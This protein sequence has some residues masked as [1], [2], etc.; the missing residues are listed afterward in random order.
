MFEPDQS[1]MEPWNKIIHQ[2]GL[3]QHAAHYYT[4]ESFF[5][6]SISCFANEAL[7]RG[8][9]V[10]LVSRPAHVV[11]IESF[12]RHEHGRDPEVLKRD[13]RLFVFDAEKTLDKFM[14]PA[15]PDWQLFEK[16]IGGAVAEASRNA[17]VCAHGEMVDI[18]WHRGERGS[19]LLLEDYWNRLLQRGNFSLFC[20]YSIDPLSV[21]SFGEDFRNICRTHSIVLPPEDPERFQGAVEGAIHETLGP[22]LFSMVASL[23]VMEDRRKLVPSARK[24][25]LWLSR[26]MP[27]T[28]QKVLRHAKRKIEMS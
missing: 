28:V 1:P 5:A 27:L 21:E 7:N 8:H 23:S 20:G 10:L 3:G 11:Q 19:V 18:L 12:L 26:N 22:S 16:V 9:N 4:D 14:T 24:Y 6:R 2:I 25:L 17:P 13:A 15:G